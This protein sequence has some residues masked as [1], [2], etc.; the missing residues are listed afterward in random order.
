MDVSVCRWI[1]TLPL[2]TKDMVPKTSRSETAWR[3]VAPSILRIHMNF[4]L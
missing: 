3:S 1:D 4:T 2:P